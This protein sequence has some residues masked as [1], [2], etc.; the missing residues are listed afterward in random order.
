MHDVACRGTYF[1]RCVVSRSSPLAAQL[2]LPHGV[3]ALLVAKHGALLGKAHI[4][5]FGGADIWEEEVRQSCVDA[6]LVHGCSMLQTMCMHDV[7]DR[8]GQL[9]QM[10]ILAS[11]LAVCENINGLHSADDPGGVPRC[12][13]GLPAGA[14]IPAAVQGVVSRRQR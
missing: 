3:P 13:V 8:P 14:V 7:R 4:D 11:M 5:Q 10:V 12:A 6:V 2:Q 9:G 1:A